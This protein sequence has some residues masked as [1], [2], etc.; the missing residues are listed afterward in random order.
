ME[1]PH[2]NIPQPQAPK[3]ANYPMINI[4]AAQKPASVRKA[5]AVLI[6][7]FGGSHSRIFIL[8]PFP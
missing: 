1:T 2:I 6:N 3:A 4:E 7:E 5:A 8:E